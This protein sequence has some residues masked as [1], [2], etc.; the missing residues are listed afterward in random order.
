MEKLQILS[1]DKVA[2]CLEEKLYPLAQA[3]VVFIGFSLPEEFG[4]SNELQ[5][6]D[7][8][9][10]S[11]IGLG[12]NSVEMGRSFVLKTIEDVFSGEY[13][14]FVPEGS[15]FCLTEEGDGLFTLSVVPPESEV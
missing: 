1:I 12:P 4:E 2:E 9:Q 13:G 7:L 3:R 6:G 11:S 10:L 5:F 15:K 8:K 14:L